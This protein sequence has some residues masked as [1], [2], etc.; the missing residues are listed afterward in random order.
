MS[1]TPRIAVPVFAIAAA[2][3][4]AGCAGTPDSATGSNQGGDGSTPE[5]TVSAPPTVDELALDTWGEQVM[6]GEGER[7]FGLLKPG[8]T[9]EAVDISADS[10][11]WVAQVVCVSDVSVT[12]RATVVTNGVEATTDIPCAVTAEGEATPTSIAYQGG[13]SVTVSFSA[14]QLTGYVVWQ[15]TA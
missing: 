4:F 7:R 6:P 15:H 5:I 9:M 8:T 12:M 14:P 3:A 10:G 1:R 2:L 13:A 11:A